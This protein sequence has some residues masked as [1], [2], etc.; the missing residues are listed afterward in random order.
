VIPNA[1]AA[2]ASCR[3]LGGED[4]L[5][6]CGEVDF[7]PCLMMRRMLESTLGLSKQVKEGGTGGGGAGAGFI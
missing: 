1:A 4:L 5:S 2:A 6:L 3:Y 7:P